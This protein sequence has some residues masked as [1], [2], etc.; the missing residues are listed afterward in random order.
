LI[1]EL[2][3]FFLEEISSIEEQGFFVLKIEILLFYH[4][5]N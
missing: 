4:L 2:A 5:K 1:W 3:L